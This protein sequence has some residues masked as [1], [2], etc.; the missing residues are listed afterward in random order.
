VEYTVYFLSS[1]GS[2]VRDVKFCDL[3]PAKMTY[4]P[5][6]LQ[7]GYNTSALTDPTGAG[8][9]LTDA[10]DADKGTFFAGGTAAPPICTNSNANG[11]ND[12]NP[13]TNDTG[14]VFVQIVDAS[15]NMP[16]ATGAGTPAGSYGFVRFRAKVN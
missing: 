11:G 16:Y 7:L 15:T 4:V 14:A 5:G 12:N 6:S 9:T 13:G 1:G 8:T 2:P 3:I 10:A